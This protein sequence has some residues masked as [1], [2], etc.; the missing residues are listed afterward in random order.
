MKLK[1]IKMSFELL[2]PINAEV[3]EMGLE[4]IHHEIMGGEWSGHD[5][6]IDNVEILEGSE[7]INAACDEHATD[8]EFF[9][10]DEN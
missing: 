4:E 3:G 2:M 1:R 10:P 8:V 5:L 7:A 9:F 6:K